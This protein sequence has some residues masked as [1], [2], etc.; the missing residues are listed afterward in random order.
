[1]F[2]DAHCHLSFPDFDADRNDVLQ[3]LQAAKV[4]LLIDPGTDVTTSKNSIALAQEVDCVYANV[5]LHP[6]EATQPIGDDVFAQL[7]ALAHQPKVVGLGEIGLD[8]HY[9][10][11][12]ASAQQAAFREM[13]RMAI[14]L[15]MPVVIHSRDAWSDTLRL[16]DEEQHSALRGIMHCFSGD[17]AIAKECIQRGFKLS[18]PGTLTYKK[19]LLPEVVAQVALD[20]LLTETDAPYLAPVPHRGK[21]NEPAY[22][23]LVTEAI[24]RIRSLSVEDAATAIYRNTLSVFE[25]INNGG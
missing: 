16:L 11:C 23:A 13:L 20:D 4:S 19:S 6:H 15:D 12:N 22:V 18:I 5:G 21:R 3:R 25:R 17:A 8:Y 1:M 14:R 9:P 10:D 24:A 7:E 2:I